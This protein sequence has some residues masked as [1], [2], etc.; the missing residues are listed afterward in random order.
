MTFFLFR[1]I[2]NEWLSE[3]RKTWTQNFFYAA[4]FKRKYEAENK[5]EELLGKGHDAYVMQ[6]N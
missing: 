1:P 4:E 5:A 3:D 6:L 2:A